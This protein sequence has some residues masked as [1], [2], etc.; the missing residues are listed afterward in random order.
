[1]NLLQRRGSSSV[2]PLPSP[3][4]QSSP[5][6]PSSHLALPTFPGMSAP[7][8]TTS[9]TGSSIHRASSR[10]SQR[11][12]RVPSPSPRFNPPA[13]PSASTSTGHLIGGS[14]SGAGPAAG[15]SG[16]TSASMSQTSS[17]SGSRSGS[18]ISTPRMLS[19]RGSNREQGKPPSLLLRKDSA[20]EKGKAREREDDPSQSGASSSQT[21][22]TGWYEGW[23][24][25]MLETGSAE[26]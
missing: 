16:S 7:I 1:M 22:A 18:L 11:S 13:L 24:T 3:S 17:A 19:R 21:T 4:I 6:L 26:V 9:S 14:G 10:T 8:P 5:Q 20:K 23:K 2:S 25:P 12:G 15:G